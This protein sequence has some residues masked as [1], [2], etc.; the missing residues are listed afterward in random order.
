MVSHECAL[1]A[2]FAS[3]TF[4]TFDRANPREIPRVH[5]D[6]YTRSGVHNSGFSVALGRLSLRIVVPR[7]ARDTAWPAVQ[8]DLWTSIWGLCV[9]YLTDH[10]YILL[11]EPYLRY[12]SSFLLPSFLP[13]FHPS[14]RIA[15]TARPFSL[16][17][18]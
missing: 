3:V 11:L 12:G 6:V 7:V 8:R 5:V 17:L 10:N 13:S 4:P 18:R 1:S 16:Y 14:T 15:R 9:T 2:N